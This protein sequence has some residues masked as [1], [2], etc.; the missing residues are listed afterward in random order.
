M[1]RPCASC[2]LVL[3]TL[4]LI[5]G[6]AAPKSTADIYLWQLIGGGVATVIAPI[7]YT[8]KV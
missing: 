6:T 7:A 2:L 5:F 1:A 8:Q 3:Q 4:D